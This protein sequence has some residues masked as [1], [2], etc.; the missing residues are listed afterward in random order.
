[1]PARYQKLVIDYERYADPDDGFSTVPYDK[2][3]HQVECRYPEP[4]LT[5]PASG[6]GSN[7]LLHIERQL[8]GLEVFRP[9]IKAYIKKFSGNVVTTEE[10]RAHLY[11]FFG[12]QENG[13]EYVNK[14]DE[15]KW[16]EVGSAL[17]IRRDWR[18]H[19]LRS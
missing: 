16:D 15:I 14:L 1:M 12:S 7:F 19:F 11:D 2:Y 10:W 4:E 17:H 5:L 3:V 18:A 13:K 8:G 9:Y 6:R